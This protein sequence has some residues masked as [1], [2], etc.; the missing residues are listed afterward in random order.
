MIRAPIFVAIAGAACT[1][2]SASAVFSRGTSFDPVVVSRGCSG[3]PDP[4][5]RLNAVT[6]EYGG[7]CYEHTFAACWDGSVQKTAPPRLSLVLLHR[8]DDDPCLALIMR[9]ITIDVADLAFEVGSATVLG[10][11][12]P[13][14]L[15]GP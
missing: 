7:G 6:V 5:L 1:S 8:G 4:G 13:I 11:H 14:E 10:Q 15:V 12:G 3:T 2:D 9:N